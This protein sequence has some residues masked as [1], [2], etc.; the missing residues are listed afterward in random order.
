ME[1]KIEGF[2]RFHGDR[3][4]HLALHPGKLD[5]GEVTTANCGLARH[6]A[7]HRHEA[8]GGLLPGVSIPEDGF[9]SSIGQVLIRQN[10]DHHR[11]R[12]T[13]E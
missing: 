13:F 8:D 10:V 3:A 6:L 9:N 4:N 7:L 1:Q 11:A 2:G 5:G 12:R